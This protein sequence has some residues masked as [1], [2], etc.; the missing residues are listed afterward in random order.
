MDLR[1]GSEDRVVATDA[2]AVLIII[3]LGMAHLIELGLGKGE[4]EGGMHEYAPHNLANVQL[5]FITC[6]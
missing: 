1:H 3:P 5:V 4:R 2:G 6:V